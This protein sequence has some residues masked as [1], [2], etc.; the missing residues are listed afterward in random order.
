MKRAITFWATA[1]NYL[2]KNCDLSTLLFVLAFIEWTVHTSHTCTLDHRIMWR[3][4]LPISPCI[5]ARSVK[6]YIFRWSYRWVGDLNDAKLLR[7]ISS[8]INNNVAVEHSEP[9]LIV[10]WRYSIRPCWRL[11]HYGVYYVECAGHEPFLF[12]A[13][14]SYIARC[15]WRALSL[16]YSRV[17]KPLPRTVQPRFISGRVMKKKTL[18]N[19]SY[20]FNPA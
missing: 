15:W 16:C 11:K 12:S 1:V 5:M 19:A 9:S 8:T 17:Q 20:S 4:L 14:H 10:T 3:N 13:G 6:E 18:T 2:I 7:L